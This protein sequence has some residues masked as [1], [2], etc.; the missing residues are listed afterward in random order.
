MPLSTDS[1]VFRRPFRTILDEWGWGVPDAFS[2]PSFLLFTFETLLFPPY[3][4]VGPWGVRF[5]EGFSRRSFPWRAVDGFDVGDPAHPNHAY[6]LIKRSLDPLDWRLGEPVE[7]PELTS[8]TPLELVSH[9]R[10]AQSRFQ[11]KPHPPAG[12]RLE[13]DRK[14]TEGR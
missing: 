14:A 11:E 8:P 10:E 9:L 12:T 13:T 5:R 7:L 4:S 6:I 1:I 2:L 3:V